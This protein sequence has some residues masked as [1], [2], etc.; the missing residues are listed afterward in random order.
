MIYNGYVLYYI[1]NQQG[2]V[3]RINKED[4]FMKKWIWILISIPALLVLLVCGILIAEDVQEQILNRELAGVQLQRAVRFALDGFPEAYEHLEFYFN[5]GEKEYMIYQ[6]GE[7]LLSGIRTKD[8]ETTYYTDADSPVFEAVREPIHNLLQDSN[9]TY[10]YDIAHSGELP[11]WV[12]PGE[13]YL[14]CERPGYEDCVEIMV[15]ND[16]GYGTYIRWD[17]AHTTDDVTLYLC[18]RETPV[19]TTKDSIYVTGWGYLPEE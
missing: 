18:M 16:V 14:D 8:G 10:S 6:N 5:D 2:D 9:V 3:T 15:C 17:I 1:L 13:P 19:K 7:R 11:L 12:F 4:N